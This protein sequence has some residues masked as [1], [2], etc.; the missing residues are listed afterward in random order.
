ML[1]Q[2][3]NEKEKFWGED[4]ESNYKS[5]INVADDIW[6]VS[7]HIDY[8][9]NKSSLVKFIRIGI[10]I[11]LFGL[12]LLIIII[13]FFKTNKNLS[14][15]VHSLVYDDIL[16]GLPNRRAIEDRI[17]HL[18]K[19]N[20][21]FSIA[22]LDLDN[23]KDIND[24]LGHSYGD[25]VLIE[26]ANRLKEQNF[27]ESYRWGGDEFVFIGVMNLDDFIN[28]MEEI[29]KKLSKT[30][31]LNGEEYLIT[32]S[33]G[34]CSYPIDATTKEELIKLADTT[35]YNVKEKGKN[36][37]KVYDVEIG[38][39]IL[40]KMRIERLIDESIKKDKFEIYYQA[41]L[42][43]KDNKIIGFEALIRMKDND[44]KFISPAKFIPIAEKSHFINLIDE[45]VINKV[46]KDLNEWNK[47]GF[48]FSVSINISA[49]HFSMEFANYIDKKIK[50]YNINPTRVEIE[51][52]ESVVIENLNK[53]KKFLI[54]LSSIG[55]RVALDDFGTGY[56][57]LSYISKLY[58]STLKIDK[59]FINKMIYNNNEYHIIKSVVEM[60]KE[61]GIKSIAEGVE[62]KEQ[63]E[64]VKNLN[65]D[66]YQGYYLSKPIPKY[67]V[68]DFLNNF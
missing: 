8:K 43:L 27:F 12:S 54:K 63:L 65:Y 32:S 34:I 18:I 67:E 62:T 40:E 7:T 19:N 56:S 45:Y 33:L 60:V 21:E 41:Q 61:L 10:S 51:I 16:T 66:A 46:L 38:K 49:N 64:L 44:G 3:N 14:S 50:Y 22:F 68:I 13:S 17:N 26:I 47:K 4:F 6:T 53:A 23:F 42:G 20:S 31:E 11:I 35:M 25:K 28:K 52:T 2:L 5:V 36:S 30:I 9:L 39:S 48:D 1:Y 55:V 15:R 58:L 37:F 59:S 24:T 29:Q 57:S